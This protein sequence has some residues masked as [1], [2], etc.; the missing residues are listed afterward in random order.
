MNRTR[1]GFTLVELLVVIGI[2][3]ILMA[4]LFP[5]IATA[6]LNAKTN[7]MSM[8]GKNLFTAIM[9]S[10]VERE[11]AGLGEVWPQEDN[12]GVDDDEKEFIGAS[13]S[14]KWFEYLFD[15]QH[16]GTTEW[17][18]YVGV[19]VDA[20]AG[21]EVTAF[22]GGT[23]LNKDNV[24]WLVVQNLQSSVIDVTP[25]MVT[26]NVDF[27]TLGSSLSKFS[28]SETTALECGKTYDKPFANKAWVLVRKSGASQVITAKYSKLNIVFNRQGFDNSTLQ[29]Q[30]KYLDL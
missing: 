11:A 29:H 2:L 6:M 19:G 20:I 5:A 8:K 15:I 7:A 22:S 10:N 27:Q 21:A 3:G 1:K 12:S 18:P 16:Y 4:A 24:A 28:G 9:A 30:L 25:I 13:T 17:K 23:S 14:T 26:R